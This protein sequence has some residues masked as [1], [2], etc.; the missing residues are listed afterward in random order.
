M[1]AVAAGAFLLSCLTLSL[2]WAAGPDKT[3]TWSDIDCSKSRIYYGPGLRCQATNVVT[4]EGNV[5]SFRR[6]GAFGTLRQGY[7]QVFLWEAQN[8]FSYIPIDT[9]TPD[10]IKWVYGN[11]KDATQ[12]G[13]VG[14]YRDADYASFRDG[15]YSCAGFRR[16]GKERRGG[17]YEWIMGGVLCAPA[18][19]ALSNEQFA[20]FIDRVRLQ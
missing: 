18:G 3:Y 17:G 15:Q 4:T 8:G 20:Q 6:Y 7:V 16:A 5:G 19:Q 12:F 1:R 13:A 14:R 11:G 9:T 2:A 10:F